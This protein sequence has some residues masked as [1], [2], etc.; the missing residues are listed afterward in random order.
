MCKNYKSLIANNIA[1]KLLILAMD[2]S[3]LLSKIVGNDVASIVKQYQEP[4]T[5]DI[6]DLIQCSCYERVF[7][8]L[9]MMSSECLPDKL[10]YKYIEAAHVSGDKFMQDRF[11]N[12]A[13]LLFAASIVGNIEYV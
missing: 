9:S 5:S 3:A 13:T 11:S 8:S 10:M 1:Y 7:E 6:C 4:K 2:Y 12:D